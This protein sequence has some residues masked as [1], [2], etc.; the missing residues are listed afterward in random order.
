MFRRLGIVISSRLIFTG[1]VIAVILQRLLEL[2]ISK[3]NADYLLT[4]GGQLHHDNALNPVKV[5]QVAWFVAMLV[6]VWGLNRP[7]IPALSAIGAIATLAGQYLRYLSMQALG[8]RWTLQLIAI[9]AVPRINTGIYRYLRHPNW[10]G[11]ALEIAAVP[12]I[13]TAYLSA[14]IFS[15]ANAILLTQRI[16]A[17]EEVLKGSRETSYVS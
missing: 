9:P 10:L 12:L 14:L 3:T 5:L 8:S 6:E 13:H 11:V 7:F 1:I 4:H 16:Q 2:R 17:E 15:I